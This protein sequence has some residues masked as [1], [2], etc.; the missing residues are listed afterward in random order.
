MRPRRRDVCVDSDHIRG[1]VHCGS[2]VGERERE[3][4]RHGWSY[5]LR[6]VRTGQKHIDLKILS[7]P[8]AACCIAD[9]V[10]RYFELRTH[11]QGRTQS[12]YRGQKYEPPE[13]RRFGP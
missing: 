9:A 10:C 5:R 12:I 4:E 7:A 3:R 11:F 8:L 13:L 2:V 6:E 1:L